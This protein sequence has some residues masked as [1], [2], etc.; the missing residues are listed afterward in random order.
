MM[1]KNNQQTCPECGSI[2][3]SYQTESEGVEINGRYVTIDVDY[4][5][6]NSCGS[7]VVIPEQARKNDRKIGNFNRKIADRRYSGFYDDVNNW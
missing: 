5:M 3:L 7:D 4:C 2:N 1:Q 6:C